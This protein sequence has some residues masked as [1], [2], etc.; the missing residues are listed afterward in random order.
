MADDS[1]ETDTDAYDPEDHQA[2]G[3]ADTL[4]SAQEIR[5]DPQR[6][7][8]ALAHLQAHA[9]MSRMATANEHRSFARKTGQRMKA[10]FNK[11]SGANTSPFQQELDKEKD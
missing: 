4:R 10:A 9:K 6:H 8:K 5:S 7:K 11:G 3:D 2:R 1:E